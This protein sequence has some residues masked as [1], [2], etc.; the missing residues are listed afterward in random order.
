VPDDVQV[1]SLSKQARQQCLSESA[2]KAALEHKGYR[3]IMPGVFFDT[4]DELKVNVLKGVMSL[5]TMKSGMVLSEP[6][7]HLMLDRTSK[8][9]D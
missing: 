9:I 1:I 6:H 3:L 4:L 5:P 8:G 7:R 2:V